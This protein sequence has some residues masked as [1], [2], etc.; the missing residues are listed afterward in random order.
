MQ[1]K[2]SLMNVVDNPIQQEWFSRNKLGQDGQAVACL[3]P[4][5]ELKLSIQAN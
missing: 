2:L 1:E 4:R 5:T 3:V